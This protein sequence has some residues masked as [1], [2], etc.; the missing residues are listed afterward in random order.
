MRSVA[1]THDR[2]GPA[3]DQ[4]D[5]VA[6]VGLQNEKRWV[7]IKKKNYAR[8]EEAH[9]KFHGAPISRLASY[10]KTHRRYN[11]AFSLYPSFDQEC[12][13]HGCG[14]PIVLH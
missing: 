12:P 9:Y 14:L 13:P 5:T 11:V 3:L 8:L 1:Y 10:T 4:L 7:G 6:L 2:L